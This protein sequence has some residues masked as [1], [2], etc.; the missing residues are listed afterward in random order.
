M[1]IFGIIHRNTV[2]RQL[3]IQTRGT[4][5]IDIVT[6][7]KLERHI[8]VRQNHI[9]G[10]IQRR[11]GGHLP[12]ANL[13]NHGIIDVQRVIDLMTITRVNRHILERTRP[14]I[15]GCVCVVRRQRNLMVRH[16]TIR[17]QLQR[18]RI[19]PA[20]VIIALIV[21]ID[22]NRNRHHIAAVEQLHL[23]D[24]FGRNRCADRIVGH[25]VLVGNLNFDAVND[26]NTS[27][28]TVNIIDRQVIPSPSPIIRGIQINRLAGCHTVGIQFRDDTVRPIAVVV[29]IIRPVNPSRNRAGAGGV[30][31]M[32]DVILCR[33]RIAKAGQLLL[34]ILR[35]LNAV[36]NRQTVFI[37]SQTSHTICPCTLV[38]RDI[39]GLNKHR[40]IV[41]NGLIQVNHDMLR[42]HIVAVVFVMPVHREVHGLCLGDMRQLHI[43][44]VG[45]RKIV[46]LDST[47]IAGRAGAITHDI[48]IV[49]RGLGQ[50]RSLVAQ[51]FLLLAVGV[52]DIV[53]VQRLTINFKDLDCIN[54]FHTGLT[55]GIL[56]H[57]GERVVPVIGFF[58]TGN[59]HTIRGAGHCHRLFTGSVGIQLQDNILGANVVIVL[60]VVPVDI[61]RHR[62]GIRV[63]RDNHLRGHFL[64][65]AVCALNPAVFKRTFRDKCVQVRSHD[66]MIDGFQSVVIDRILEAVGIK[67]EH[68]RPLACCH[69]ID[70]IRMNR[71]RR[72]LDVL[73]L[74]RVVVPLIGH[75]RH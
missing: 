28:R 58:I 60:A 26:F 31:Q 9:P 38:F 33:D 15:A 50:I 39:Q 13:G 71:L 5:T 52:D 10:Q 63:L 14:N 30:I 18:H 32:H 69:G 73:P 27:R 67:F 70:I 25:T 36:P 49:L 8:H 17:H 74:I 4:L 43:S 75:Q 12:I 61:G 29:V 48:V 68:A 56:G 55:L 6:V 1:Q 35:N 51:D 46:C 16:F 22:R 11:A 47:F 24:F 65:I 64:L 72:H 54:Q 7:V 19:R 2:G 34:D 53:A 40:R 66:Q 59:G 37:A 62:N 20:L 57:T 21:P 3:Q 42:P 23:Q 41:A 44:P 45:L